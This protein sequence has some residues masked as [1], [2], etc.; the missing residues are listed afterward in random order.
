LT[1]LSFA[2]AGQHTPFP[3]PGFDALNDVKL[4]PLINH[5]S[6]PSFGRF[7]RYQ[8]NPLHVTMPRKALVAVIPFDGEVLRVRRF[9]RATVSFI[10]V[11]ANAAAGF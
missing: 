10:A 3:N 5:F 6:I 7:R 9:D 11:K 2:S 1:I 4:D 8:L